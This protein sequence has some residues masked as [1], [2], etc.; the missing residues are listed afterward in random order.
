[1]WSRVLR[2]RMKELIICL[3]ISPRVL[4]KHLVLSC[5]L[6]N[7]DYVNPHIY[8]VYCVTNHHIPNVFFNLGYVVTRIYLARCVFMRTYIVRCLATRILFNSVYVT[9]RTYL[10]RYVATSTYLVRCVITRT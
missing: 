10:V 5:I 4:I 8:L 3:T 7:A 2:S 1:M 6:F 9:T